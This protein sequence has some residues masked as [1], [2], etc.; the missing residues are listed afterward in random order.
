MSTR[1]FL[2]YFLDMF[3]FKMAKQCIFLKVFK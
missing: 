3:I 1:G 2:F